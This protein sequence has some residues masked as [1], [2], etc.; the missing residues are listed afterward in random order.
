MEGRLPVETGEGHIRGGVPVVVSGRESRSRGEGGQEADRF[1]KPGES[2]DIDARTDKIWLLRMQRKPYPWS[3]EK[4]EGKYLCLADGCHK[5]GQ[6]NAGQ[7]RG[8]PQV[9]RFCYGLWSAE[10]ETKSACS[11]RGGLRETAG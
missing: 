2:V 4:P 10:C 11:V 3:R 6:E 7:R 9:A 8:D 1:L 5:R